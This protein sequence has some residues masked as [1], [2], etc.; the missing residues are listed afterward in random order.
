MIGTKVGQWTVSQEIGDG[1][2]AFVFKGES[3]SEVVAIKMLRPSIADEDSLEKRFLIEA[4]ALEELKHKNI[5]GF[6]GYFFQNGYHYLA[7]E[8]MDQGSVEDLINT[9]GPIPP[10]YVIPLF[11]KILAGV[12]FAH[13][14]GYVHRDI[15]PSN[16]LLDSGGEAKL[17]DFGIAKVMH[18]GQGL[19][20]K[21][22]VLGTTLYM[23]PEF[24]TKGVVS[25]KTDIYALGVTLYEMLTTR[26]PFEFERDDE[27]LIT[28]ARRV[29]REKPV[30]PSTHRPIPRE[31]ERVV[32]KSIAQNPRDRY[33]TAKE[34]AK[35]L[36]RS[37][38]DLVKRS[39]VIP[40][41]QAMTMYLEVEDLQDDFE[42]DYG[43]A[44]T[45]SSRALVVAAVV[46]VALGVPWLL[47]A[48]GE[49]PLKLTGAAV[50]LALA[51]VAYRLVPRPR[52]QEPLVL[53]PPPPAPSELEQDDE[54]SIGDFSD[55][56]I[57]FHDGIQQGEP[58]KMTE[59]SELNAFL[60]VVEGPDKG[61][62]FGLRPISR[63]GRDLRID[64]RPHDREISR[65][66]AVI[67]FDGVG[68]T[69]EDAGS[70]NGTFVNETLV[71]GK[72][73]LSP[74]DILRVGASSMRFDFDSN[75]GGDDDDTVAPANP[76]PM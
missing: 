68:F 51:A 13:S 4:E 74:G 8:Y 45:S 47:F 21:G 57:P 5:V 25:V 56:T 70:T 43:D 29:C 64:I 38:P 37:F 39:L 36:A 46:A 44:E 18:G 71:E 33:K 23:S 75:A 73:R 16:I 40:S 35:D 58:F 7:L 32:M 30:P 49:W 52:V 54:S 26:K 9:M 2:H 3:D 48:G 50:A 31:L 60:V 62:R 63:I 53:S 66:H 28:Y 42:G 34:L 12:R 65:Q 20:A 76:G 59:V 1:G 61:R 55:D 11:Y 15:K 24:I 10:R 67:T 72:V 22:F 19:T 6:M 14:R 41:G 27:P 17:T 69:V